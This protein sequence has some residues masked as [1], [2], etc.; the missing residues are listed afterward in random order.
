MP[1]ETRMDN[2]LPMVK[3]G[4]LRAMTSNQKLAKLAGRSQHAVLLLLLALPV[5]A[6]DANWPQFRGPRGDG[7]SASTGLP[8]HW[9]EQSKEGGIKWKVPIHRRAWSSPVSWGS[10]VWVTSATE[11]APELFAA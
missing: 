11:N 2:S 3:L 1:S 7:S 8:L 10:Q 5:C 6:Q 9:S 4:G